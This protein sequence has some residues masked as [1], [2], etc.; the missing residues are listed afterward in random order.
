MLLLLY[1]SSSLLLIHGQCPDF[2]NLSSPNVTCQYG[3]THN[4]M[5]YTGIILGRHTVIAQQGSDPNTGHQLPF[6]PPGEHAVVKLG[7]EQVGAQAEA[8]TYHFTVDTNQA[9]LLLKFAVVFEDPEHPSPDQPRFV[10]RVLNAAGQLVDEC[11]EYDVTAAGNIPGFQNYISG[12]HNI[13]WRPWTNVGIDLSNYIGQT[14]RVQFVTYDCSRFGHYGYAY[15]TASCINNQLALNGCNGDQMTLI[16][17]SD[18]VSYSWNNGSTDI[19]ATYTINGTSTANC[20]ITSVTGCHFMLSGTITTETNIPSS[21]I[22]IYDTICEGDVYNQNFFNLPIQ[23]DI[24]THVFR[25][26]FFISDVCSE[27][28]VTSTLFLTILPHY[29][30]IYE[31][32]CQGMDYNSNGFHYTNL[33]TGSFT[34]TLIT[35]QNAGCDLITILHLTVNSSLMLN[36]SIIGETSVC[37]NEVFSYTLSNIEGLAL[38]HWVVPDGVI[39]LTGQETSEVNL[40]F[41]NEAPNPAEFSLLGA[42][43]CGSGSIP[44]SVTHFPTYHVFIQDSICTGNDYHHNGFDIARQ[45]STGC[46]SFTNH[47]ATR[48][49]CDSVYILQLLVTN[50]PSLTTLAQ[51]AEICLGQSTIVHALGENAGLIQGVHSLSTIAIG[52]I[53]CT[54]NTIVKPSVWPM[55]GKTAMGIVFYVD[56]TDEHGW[57]VHLQDQGTSVPWTPDGL[58][59]DIPSL[60][61]YINSRDAVMDLDG[62]L[63]TA[64][65]QNAGNASTYP[66]AYAVDFAN[67]WY[68]PAIGQLRIL[69]SEINTINTSLQIVGGTQFPVNT[70]WDYWSSTEASFN[71]A[72]LSASHGTIHNWIKGIGYR[73]RSIR[74]F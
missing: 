52:D 11:A 27:G 26:T 18:F 7:N 28:D 72:Y 1:L 55:E 40:Y 44:L 32:A 34:D 48:Q 2:T 71:M 46:F 35:T 31:T 63:N 57:A 59:T 70:G 67:G 65:I 50:T 12:R 74:S 45:D 73:V 3:D 53:L 9:I 33:Q 58:E 23:N 16:A 49:G 24:G 17:P 14:V 19:S 69:T 29:N 66:A 37:S 47:Y 56:N 41:T 15:F 43:G 38:I 10:V 61:N 22:I 21:N 20:L 6:L 62:Y 36:N 4:P 30:H 39:I 42:N 54:D 64:N 51:P 5:Q 25:N 8:I 13:R 68:L 60:T